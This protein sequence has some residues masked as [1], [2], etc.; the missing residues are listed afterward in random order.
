[1][2]AAPEPCSAILST[3]VTVTVT[4]AMAPPNSPPTRTCG[5]AEHGSGAFV[6]PGGELGNM[7]LLLR[8]GAGG[9]TVPN[10][11]Q[12]ERFHQDPMMSSSQKGSLPSHRACVFRH[13]NLP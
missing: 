13:V 7:V 8:D 12:S 1:V 5:V 3:V 11:V 6:T 4:E 10:D 2:K 9:G